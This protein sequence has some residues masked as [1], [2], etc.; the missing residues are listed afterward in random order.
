MNLERILGSGRNFFKRVALATAVTAASLIA[1][2]CP[3]VPPVPPI[4]SNP[5]SLNANGGSTIV[6]T[7][8]EAETI[9]R[10]TDNEVYFT[11]P[12]DYLKIGD[13]IAADITESTP[14]GFLREITDISSDRKIVH[15]QQAS[16]EDA[17][18]NTDFEFSAILSQDGARVL[19]REE[20][21]DL[22]G[23]INLI[24]FNFNTDVNNI[25]ILDIDGNPNN[26]I[27]VTANAHAE[28]GL[29]VII[30]G[31][32]EGYTIKKFEFRTVTRESS[33]L[34]INANLLAAVLDKE[35]VIKEF[36]LPSFTIGYIPTPL[37]GVFIPLTVNPRIDF[38]VGADGYV[39]PI[40]ADISQEAS[41]NVGILYEN[42]Q[43]NTINE[44]EKNFEFI[45]NKLTEIK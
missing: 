8:E 34:E 2:A 14:D 42:N 11:N 44:F 22:E 17:V 23:E 26:G 15:T 25:P 9:S 43:W 16:L 1:T 18:E 45:N 33:S 38:I 6:L 30:G 3:P 10:V 4:P 40:T 13:I 28:F 31:K 29:K 12:I 24:D 39:A 27:D 5:T 41:L 35:V 7:Q 20:A 37:P 32:I 36:R 19:S 21:R